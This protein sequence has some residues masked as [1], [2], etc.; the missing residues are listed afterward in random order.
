MVKQPFDLY[1]FDRHLH[2]MMQGTK[3]LYQ[4]DEIDIVGQGLPIVLFHLF[5]KAQSNFELKEVKWYSGLQ[6]MVVI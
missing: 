1:V 5:L 3:I 6:P 2:K 4:N